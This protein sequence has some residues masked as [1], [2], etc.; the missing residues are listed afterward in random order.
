MALDLVAIR[1]GIVGALDT[2]DGL[3]VAGFATDSPPPPPAAIVMPGSDNG[4]DYHL[5]FGRGLCK[6]PYRVVLLAARDNPA[7]SQDLLDGYLSAGT[8]QT[9]SVLDA[10]YAD[11]TLGGTVD[12]LVVDG[13]DNYGRIEWGGVLWLGA[14]VN[15]TV[16]TKRN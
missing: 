6:I 15:L 14:V 10:L 3:N 13:F 7:G 5:S 9:S 16:Q 11:K 1:G 12:D 2:I 8:G 4:V